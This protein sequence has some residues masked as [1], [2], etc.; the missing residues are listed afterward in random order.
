V[1]D[2]G[3]RNELVVGLFLFIGLLLL[4]GLILQFGRFDEYFGHQYKITVLFDDASGLIKGSEVRMGG[5]RIGRVSKL[6]ELTESVQVQ[7]QLAIDK[8]TRIPIGSTFRIDS[9]TLLGDKLIV[10]IPPAKMIGAFIDPGSHLRGSGPTGLE[11]LQNQAQTVSEEVIRMLKEIDGT[12]KKADTAVEDIQAAS[13]QLNESLGKINQTVLDEDNLS[14]LDKTL[15]NLAD[16]SSQW[17]QTSGKLDPAIDE[18]KS[19][20]GAMK[21][22]LSNADEAIATIKPALKGVPEA[23]DHIKTTAEKAGDT[24]DR[25]KRGEGML[26]A[27]AS[28]NDVAFDFK[29]FMKNLRQ[30]GILLYRNEDSKPT[31]AAP[32][33]KSAGGKWR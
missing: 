1:S 2:S 26:G 24:L 5:A 13:K 19:A 6:P 21:K 29:A 32:P 28:D 10:I 25:M 7:V 12:L 20:A 17:K 4:G 16:V 33:R 8:N 22:T 11:A 30:H 3:K 23:V 27:F 14:H 31:P 9:A 15:A 18:I